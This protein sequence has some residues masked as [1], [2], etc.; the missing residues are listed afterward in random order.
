[1]NERW[2]VRYA[3]EREAHVRECCSFR[4]RIWDDEERVD[5]RAR[6][7]DEHSRRRPTHIVSGVMPGVV[8]DIV[9]VQASLR[10]NVASGAI[11][12]LFPHICGAVNGL[13]SSDDIAKLVVDST[14]SGERADGGRGE[15]MDKTESREC[16]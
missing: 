16:P 11:R 15:E 12:A 1:M 8:E 2:A 4:D 6:K 13:D 5:R 7:R 14:I 3:I 9:H 10:S